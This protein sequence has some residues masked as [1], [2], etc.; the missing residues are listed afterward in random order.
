MTTWH[1]IVHKAGSRQLMTSWR[2]SW[3]LENRYKPH[4]LPCS[5]SFNQALCSASFPYCVTPD[6]GVGFQPQ[7]INDLI[8]SKA[9]PHKASVRPVFKISVCLCVQSN[10]WFSRRQRRNNLIY[11][12][13]SQ[14]GGSGDSPDDAMSRDSVAEAKPNKCAYRGVYCSEIA[15]YLPHLL[16]LLI[17][18]LGLRCVT[19]PEAVEGRL[20]HQT[21]KMLLCEQNRHSASTEHGIYELSSYRSRR[22]LV[23]ASRLPYGSRSIM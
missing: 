12:G 2:L 15:L 20:G 18:K 11:K 4:D 21:L 17:T 16:H 9:S 14:T 1:W 22:V 5:L 6:S 10:C 23:I 8:S 7:T 13:E 3:L 19:A